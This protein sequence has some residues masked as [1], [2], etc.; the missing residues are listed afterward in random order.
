MWEGE[1]DVSRNNLAS[2]RG[3]WWTLVHAI[4]DL[5]LAKKAVNYSSN[6]FTPNNGAK[7]PCGPTGL[8]EGLFLWAVQNNPRRLPTHLN[9]QKFPR[10]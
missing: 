3:Q 10:S 8:G 7:L 5:L 9:S 6:I 4:M 2:S 1:E